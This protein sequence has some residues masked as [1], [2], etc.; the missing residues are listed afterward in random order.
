MAKK[1]SRIVWE[2]KVAMALVFASVVLYVLHFSV[3]RDL[4]HICFWSFTSLAFLP[5]SV[6]VVTVFINRLLAAR[7]KALRLEKLNM[8][9]GAFFSSVGTD[10]LAHIAAWDPD[11]GYLIRSFGGPQAWSGFD[12]RKANRMLNKHAYDVSPE[13]EGLQELRSFLL[14]K[15]DFLLRLLEN[16]NLLEHET[17]TDLLRAVFHLAEE[18]ACRHDIASIPD[19][20]LKH[21]S[22]DV[23]RSYSLLVRQWVMYLAYLKVSFPYL[24][25]LAVR[26]NPLD[27]TA[28]P[29]VE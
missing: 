10:L 19:S 21:L 26:T 11:P 23:K 7:D 13:R 4:R 9:I 1:K 29:I 8:L 3:F 17:F 18:L 2:L 24:F 27:R 12:Q 25:S 20:D 28:S 16:P 22:G 14:E 5:L 15:M 6:L